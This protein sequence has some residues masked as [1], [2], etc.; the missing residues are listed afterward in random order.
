MPQMP[1]QPPSKGLPT[2]PWVL[3]DDNTLEQTAGA[4]L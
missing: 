2:S 3:V 4:E 1:A